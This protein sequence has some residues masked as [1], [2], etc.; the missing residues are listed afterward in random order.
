MHYFSRREQ[1]RMKKKTVATLHLCRKA[2]SLKNLNEANFPSSYN[3]CSQS[4]YF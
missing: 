1:F 4:K 3:L 2:F